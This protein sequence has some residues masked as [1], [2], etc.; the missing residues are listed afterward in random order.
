MPTMSG[1]LSPRWPSWR[2]ASWPTSSGAMATRRAA[3][4]RTPGESSAGHDASCKPSACGILT[5]MAGQM[6]VSPRPTTAQA[7]AG[8]HP[9]LERCRILPSTKG[10]ARIGDAIGAC[11]PS[12]SDL[13][14]RSVPER[15]MARRPSPAGPGWDVLIKWANLGHEHSTWEVRCC[16]P[17]L[18]LPCYCKVIGCIR[19]MSESAVLCTGPTSICL[20]QP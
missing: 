3:W 19:L 11:C 7:L 20:C 4:Q 13:A 16:P 14:C 5:G 15:F 6:V 10:E 18:R 17:L 1:S 8:C 9:L 2:S 12:V